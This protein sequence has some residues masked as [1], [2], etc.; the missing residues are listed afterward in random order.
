MQKHF[1]LRPK[2][3]PPIESK[4][5]ASKFTSP[6]AWVNYDAEKRLAQWFLTFFLPSLS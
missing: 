4:V 2:K 1:G 6:L 3:Q 5:S